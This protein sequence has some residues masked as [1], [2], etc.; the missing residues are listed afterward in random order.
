[1]TA[2]TDTELTEKA[3]MHFQKEELTEGDDKA[4]TNPGNQKRDSEMN[5]WSKQKLLILSLSLQQPH[6]EQISLEQPNLKNLNLNSK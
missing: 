6:R 2:N 3:C 4:M 5:H 1:M